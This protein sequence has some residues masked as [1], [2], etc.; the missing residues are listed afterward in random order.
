MLHIV[1]CSARQ[2]PGRSIGSEAQH[3]SGHSSIKY[4]QD[5]GA[6]LGCAD[7]NDDGS[8]EGAD[9]G[10]GVEGAEDGNVDGD[11][12]GSIVGLQA[13]GLPSGDSLNMG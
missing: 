2:L 8:A 11:G 12:D 5:D 9:E 7:G 4:P 6:E 13:G 10:S 3:A 1:F